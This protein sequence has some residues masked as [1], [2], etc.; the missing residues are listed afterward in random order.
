MNCYS[1]FATGFVCGVVA[2]MIVAAL[3]YYFEIPKL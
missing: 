2:T 3:L 1:Y